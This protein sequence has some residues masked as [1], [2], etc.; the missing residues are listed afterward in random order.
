[1]IG[2][3]KSHNDTTYTTKKSTD[4]IENKGK[5]KKIDKKTKLLKSLH[6]LLKLILL[7]LSK[8]KTSKT[9]FILKLTENSFNE[10]KS[11]ELN[12]NDCKVVNNL[13]N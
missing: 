10:N 3:S 11:K 13:R 4:N 7:I 8:L 9:Q 12:N 5:T 1:M 6:I 2:H